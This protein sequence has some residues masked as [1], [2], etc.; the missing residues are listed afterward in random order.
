MRVIA[1]V[2]T[3][4]AIGLQFV[5]PIV[6]G[7]PI[8]N[9]AAQTTTPILASR[10]IDL[11]RLAAAR[12]TITVEMAT[13]AQ[14]QGLGLS[15][16]LS[17]DEKAGMLFVFDHDDT[18]TFWM[19]DTLIPLSI[20]FIDVNGT[21]IDIQDMQPLDE[22]RHAPFRPVRMALEVNQGF[23]AKNGIV[24]GDQAKLWPGRLHLSL[25]AR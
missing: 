24:A 18:W 19:R 1:I 7:Q 13:T 9:V 16:R 5:Q 14:S 21:I 25:I 4:V 2:L 20:A 8:L 11:F 22:T 10:Q 17:L 15:G 12:T 23:F 6:F 3:I